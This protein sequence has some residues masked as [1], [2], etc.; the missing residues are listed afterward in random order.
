MT[1]MSWNFPET[2]PY[3]E[4]YWK[5]SR[6]SITNWWFITRHLAHILVFWD[7]IRIQSIFVTSIS[8]EVILFGLLKASFMKKQLVLLFL[9]ISLIGVLWRIFV[10]VVLLV[11]GY[12]RI[13]QTPKAQMCHYARMCSHPPYSRCQ[14]ILVFCF[15][16]TFQTKYFCLFCVLNV[17]QVGLLSRWALRGPRDGRSGPHGA[18]WTQPPSP[19]AD[20]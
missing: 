5:Q 7:R 12:I 3:K 15:C 8:P 19:A 1:L 10:F 4:T 18:G 13:K 20:W 14:K 16:F 9:F 17:L 6:C 2:G 11:L